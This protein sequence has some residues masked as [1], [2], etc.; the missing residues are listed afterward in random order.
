MRELKVEA[1][2]VYTLEEM[3]RTD[4]IIF[5]ATGITKG[6]LLEGV[7]RNGDIFQTET[8]LIRGKTRTI[9]M[10]KTTHDLRTKTPF[11]IPLI[12]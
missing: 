1:N 11:L 6:D 4:N 5:S 2:R 3:I 9:R 12:K 10:I 7:V 8:M